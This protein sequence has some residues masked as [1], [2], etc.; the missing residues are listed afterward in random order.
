[1]KNLFTLFCVLLPLGLSAAQTLPENVYFRAMSDEM[2]RTKKQLRV[3]GAVKP[4]FTVYRLTETEEAEISSVFGAPGQ[5]FSPSRRLF[6][7]VYMYAGDAQNNSSGFLDAHAYSFPS[8]VQ[9]VSAVPVSYE[10]IRRVLWKLTDL[11]YVQASGLYDKKMDYKRRKGLTTQVPDFSF[12]PQA[13]YAEEAAGL[14]PLDFAAYQ[15]WADELSAAAK[16]YPYIE[17]FSVQF[18]FQ[19]KTSYFLDSL[20]DF[21][22]V[23]QPN[24]LL[25]L[26]LVLRTQKGYREGL[27]ERIALP[28]QETPDPAAW[29]ERV[30]A[31][32]QQ[33]EKLYAAGE[34]EPYVG[35][36]LLR[37][38]AAAKFFDY[39]FATEVSHTKSWLADD[40]FLEKQFAGGKFKDKLG[41]RVIS[42]LF[43]V[44]DR[45]QLRSYKGR[46]LAAFMPVDDEG[47]PA[48]ELQLVKGG[49]LIALPQARGVSKKGQKNNGRARMFIEWPR[50]SVTNLFFVPKQA[51]SAEAMEEKLL[52][53]CRELDLPYCYILPSWQLPMDVTQTEEEVPSEI[54]FAERVYTQD[55]HKETVHGLKFDALSTRSLRDITAAGD[56]AQAFAMGGW[57]ERNISVV[58]PSVLVE[59][60]ELVPTERKPA[61][62]P[63][64][65]MPR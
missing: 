22:Q 20:E 60:M 45:P 61:Q 30:Q 55:G 35:P 23:S 42:S 52:A 2:Q 46:P 3:K 21:Y 49:K 26:T 9:Q 43:D 37:P 62:K 36:V 51:L 10:G 25:T 53:R 40:S 65:P 13:A 58:A 57:G 33:A 56:D 8:F 63:F 5:R 47:V 15:T 39:L 1:M 59:E 7:Q 19:Q 54:I 41:M 28:R 48:Q 32:L 12:A 44:Y 27:K 50:A 17:Q 31:L 29:T 4:Y 24:D 34:A 16:K 18:S 64:V 38:A 14:P 6:A 11:A